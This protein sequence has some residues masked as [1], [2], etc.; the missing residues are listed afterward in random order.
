MRGKSNFLPRLLAMR[1]PWS[2]L[3][4]GYFKLIYLI[5]FVGSNKDQTWAVR[6]AVTNKQSL[7]K[8]LPI[9]K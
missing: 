7:T 4:F 3:S 5:R 8:N 6:L 2:L 9:Y 1:V